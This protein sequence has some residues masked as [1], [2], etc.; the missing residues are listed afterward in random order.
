[1]NK[2]T[3][4]TKIAIFRKREIRKTIHKNEW[5]FVIVDVIAALT[6]S[7]QAKGYMKDMR[8]R[9]PEF[10]KGWGQIATPLAVPTP[11]GAQKL[12]CAKNRVQGTGKTKDERTRD[13]EA[14]GS[15]KQEARR[16]RSEVKSHKL[17]LVTCDLGLLTKNAA[18]LRG[19]ESDLFERHLLEGV[20]VAESSDR[21][22]DLDAREFSFGVKIGGNAFPEIFGCD[23]RFL[24]TDVKGV[25]RG[26]VGDSHDLFFSFSERS[27]IIDINSDD[28][29]LARFL[30][31]DR[32]HLLGVIRSAVPGIVKDEI[33]PAIQ[34]SQIRGRPGGSPDRVNNFVL[35]GPAKTELA[36]GMKAEADGFRHRREGSTF[37]GGCQRDSVERGACS[38]QER[39]RDAKLVGR[40]EG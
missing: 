1:M 36:Q 27:E 12:G 10:A 32:T 20:L 23:G 3:S 39:R 33:F 13:D 24:K 11:G 9:D 4:T 26:I 2:M 30:R 29:D 6:D 8:R 7:V 40:S 16:R 31:E 21:V 17:E 14:V 19:A 25:Y 38:G 5:W 35:A 15:Q 28:D 22:K 34:A 18:G 37:P